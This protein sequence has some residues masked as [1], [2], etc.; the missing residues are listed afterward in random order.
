[1]SSAGQLAEETGLECVVPVV[2]WKR[3]A[4]S[5]PG[6]CLSVAAAAKRTL[7]LLA[8]AEPKDGDGARP[9]AAGPSAP[10]DTRMSRW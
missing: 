6:D 4:V 1:M 7:G 2:R 10:V 8:D 3:Y 5:E 9:R